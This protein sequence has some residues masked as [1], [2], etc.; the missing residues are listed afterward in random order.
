MV[1][2]G[3]ASEKIRKLWRVRCLASSFQRVLHHARNAHAPWTPG[4]GT[5]SS[6]CG[7]SGSFNV[8]AYPT[9]SPRCRVARS[10]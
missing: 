4:I 1:S 2:F 6:N 10:E 8:E 5:Q 7:K 3:I 9:M